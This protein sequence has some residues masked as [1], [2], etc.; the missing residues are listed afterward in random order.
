MENTQIREMENGRRMGEL[1]EEYDFDKPKLGR[2]VHGEIV[3]I[4][5]KFA[6][7]DIGAHQDAMVPHKDLNQLDEDF[8]DNIAVGDEVP[9]YVTETTAYGGS[10]EVSIDKGLEEED[11]ENAVRMTESKAI[12]TFK[13]NGYNKGGLLI[14]FG[15]L[16]GFIPN[17][18]VPEVRR[19]SD[20]K[21]RQAIKRDLVGQE[22]PAQV[23]EASQADRRLVLDASAA[24]SE[25]RKARLAELSAGETIEGRVTNIV[26]YGAF[27]DLGGVDGL[28]HISNISW[29]RVKHPSEVLEEGEEIEV[30]VEKVDE[31][32]ERISL[33]RKALLP[34]PFED[35]EEAHLPGEII[36][37]EV[38]EV[39]DFG[40]FVKISDDIVG[41]VHATEMPLL[42]SSFSPA[43]FVQPG[44]EI[45]VEI[46][47]VDAER[48]RVRL[49]T[50]RTMSP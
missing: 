17:S 9:V 32:R 45:Q 26:P 7:V 34:S 11:W 39:K 22:I 14:E 49:S 16:E 40:A 27:I 43:D 44:D 8:L 2:I 37:G 36:D 3:L 5:E 31:E 38:T 50:R 35:F 1:L 6:Y 18:L 13:I 28:L 12:E 29:S 48:E 20:S 33:N 10:L 42:D 4:D 23:I 24:R 15:R 46:L 47:E 25:R 21:R 19:Q 30:L 41:L